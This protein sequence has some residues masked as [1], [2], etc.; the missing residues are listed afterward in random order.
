MNARQDTAI[1]NNAMTNMLMETAQRLALIEQYVVEY[2]K[3]SDDMEAKLAEHKLIELFGKLYKIV[4]YEEANALYDKAGLNTDIEHD[5]MD[6]EE[7][8]RILEDALMS[9]TA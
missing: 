2:E 7:A 8:Q 3:R 5:M 6:V 4:G 9:V 1:H